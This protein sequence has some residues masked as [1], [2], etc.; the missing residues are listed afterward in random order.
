MALNVGDVHT[1]TATFRNAAGTPTNPTTA[2]LRIRKPDGTQTSVTPASDGNGVYHYDIALDQVGV[3]EYGF[4]G[5]G[6]VTAAE[7]G[8]FFVSN[9]QV[10]A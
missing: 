10:L 3:W 7:P 6:A 1:V 2:S 9:S 4:I 8:D 5:T